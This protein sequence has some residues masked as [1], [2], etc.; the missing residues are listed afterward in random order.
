MSTPRYGPPRTMG[1]D[2]GRPELPGVPSYMVRKLGSEG[3]QACSGVT[4]DRPT[5]HPTHDTH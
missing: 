2:Q 4:L 1:V 5:L 3:R